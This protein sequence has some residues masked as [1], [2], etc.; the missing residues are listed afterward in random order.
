MAFSVRSTAVRAC[1]SRQQLAG[2]RAGRVPYSS[3]HGNG[4]PNDDAGAAE[5][6][7]KEEGKKIESKT[8]D[9]DEMGPLARRLQEA[10]EEALFTGGRA[11]RQAVQDAGFS[12][13][14]KAKL[15][16][17]V[18]DA[19]FKT[20]FAGA[21]AEAGLS[22]EEGPS[23]RGSFGAHQPWTGKES[24]EDAVRRMLEDATKPLK[25]E[26]R[27]Q[28]Q[29]GPIDPRIKRSP[30]VSHGHKVATARDRASAYTKMGMKENTGLSDKE[31]EE[32][33]KQLQERFQPEGRTGP[34]SISAI[35]SMANE[36]IE[37]AIARGQFKNIR[38]GKGVERDTQSSNP[39]VDTTEYLMNRM[40]QRQ[41]MVPPWI[42]KQQDLVREANSFRSRLRNDWK[43][44]A[45]R[46]IS[47]KGGSMLEQMHR[48]ELYAAAEKVHNPR[49]R[50]AEQIAVSSAVTDD[51]VMAKQLEQVE[52]L[53]DVATMALERELAAAG[54][55]A[56]VPETGL[57]RPFRD[58]D[59]ERAE[60]K[61]M[62]LA[63]ERLNGMTRSYNLMAPDLAKKPYFSLERELAVCYSTVAPLLAG[64]IQNRAT[65]AP[66]RLG[67]TGSQMGSPGSVMDKVLGK[68][69]VKIHVEADE[70]AFGF[71][72][73]WRDFWKK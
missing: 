68:D 20:E 2:S 59:W 25:P 52:E 45:A 8:K 26:L 3:Q 29:P 32:R 41:D 57:P 31:K 4:A 66:S 11:G 46:M 37:N 23:G 72:E 65:R 55:Q 53:E 70:K 1:R 9:D 24:T 40:I 51:P 28:F 43:R 30:V 21:L 6:S 19:K 38:R 47:S 63:V 18:A 58:P 44:H 13:E 35:E 39:F 5:A 14:L 50:T 27:G 48:A 69:N 22:P 42:E 62:T 17:K 16:E 15:L 54:G 71:K 12:E 36:R 34:I 33:K 60:H 67:G 56:A 61:Y 7:K 64:E 10:T 49:Q 73:W